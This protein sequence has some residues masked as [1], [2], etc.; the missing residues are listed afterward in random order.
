M[1]WAGAANIQDG[2]TIDLGQMKSVNVSSNRKVTQ[3]GPGARWHDVYS[4]L[5]SMGLSVV[6]GRVSDVGVAGLTI[7]GMLSVP[8]GHPERL[9]MTQPRR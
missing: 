8:Q 9:K 3:V 1:S 6:G 5:D 2:V 4:K 7:G